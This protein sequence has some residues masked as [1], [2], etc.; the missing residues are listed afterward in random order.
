[1]TTKKLPQRGGARSVRSTA[2]V[3]RW[4]RL[5]VEAQRL[6]RAAYAARGKKRHVFLVAASRIVMQF[7]EPR[8]DREAFR[9]AEAALERAIGKFGCVGCLAMGEETCGSGV[10]PK[11]KRRSK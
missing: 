8:K 9:R 3:P 4:R 1:M 7:N 6:V 11:P 2:R 10:G 5:V